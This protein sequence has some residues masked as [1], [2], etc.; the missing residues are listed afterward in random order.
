M[1]IKDSELIL[2]PDGSIYHLNLKPEN[3]ADTIITV[4]DQDRVEKV[5]DFFDEVVFETQK[6]EFKT[7][8][9]FYKSKKLTVISTGIGIDNIDIVINELDALANINLETREI[10]PNHHKL[11]FLRIGTSGGIQPEVGLDKFVMGK[12]GV[13]FDGLLHYYKNDA[14]NLDATA[15]LNEHLKISLKKPTPYIVDCDL[16]LASIFENNSQVISGYTGT[17]LGFYGPQGRKLRLELE[18]PDFI[19]QLASFK[20][21]D[22]KITNLEM[23]TSAIYSLAKMLGHGA[24]S[25]NAIIANRA[26]GEFSQD[27]KA[28]VKKL[29]KFTLDQLASH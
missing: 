12:A 18:D 29:I 10:K 17:N 22:Y 24:L 2:N 16:E 19:D 1:A 25:L 6:R 7:Q 9:G 20:H 14:I 27:P 11:N 4:G 26:N 8:T 5:T 23:E 3:I 15:K 28:A 13:G 21:G